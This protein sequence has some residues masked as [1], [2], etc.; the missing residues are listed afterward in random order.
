MTPAQ[1]ER[2][3]MLAEEA[4]EVVQACTKALRH[5][6]DGYHPHR[7]GTNAEDL[8]AELTDLMAIVDRMYAAGDIDRRIQ[9]RD[10]DAAWARKLAFSYHQGFHE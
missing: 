10:I 5:G 7:A 4:G 3:V 9:S 6:L 1:H 8:L 2:L